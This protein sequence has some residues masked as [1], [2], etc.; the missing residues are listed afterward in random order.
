MEYLFRKPPQVDIGELIAS[1]QEDSG[2]LIAALDQRV[3]DIALS[4]NVAWVNQTVEAYAKNNYY[5]GLVSLWGKSVDPLIVLA[6]IRDSSI[7]T[8]QRLVGSGLTIMG[9]VR[10]PIVVPQQKYKETEK[11]RA[12]LMEKYKHL[13][14]EQRVSLANAFLGDSKD[15]FCYPLAAFEILDG[16]E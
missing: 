4:G 10:P 1:L 14:A 16:L 6:E 5:Q 9:E 7:R 15:Y 2:L 12:A 3:E 8:H 11:R 13:P